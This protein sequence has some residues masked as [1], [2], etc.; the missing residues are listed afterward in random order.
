MEP[1]FG[2]A[3]PSN[4]IRV[5]KEEDDPVAQSDKAVLSMIQ[6]KEEE[7]I[8]VKPATLQGLQDRK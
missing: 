6:P 2:G 8:D 3:G 1:S 7:P 4:N 5:K